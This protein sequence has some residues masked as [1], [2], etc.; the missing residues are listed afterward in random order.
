MAKPIS[1]AQYHAIIARF[2][3]GS[4]LAD[5][6]ESTYR[7]LTQNFFDS[8]QPKNFLQAVLA[9][10]IAYQTAQAYRYRK[11]KNELI[12]RGRRKEA[13]TRLKEERDWARWRADR[14]NAMDEAMARHDPTYVPRP[15]R[16]DPCLT[17][18]S[19]PLGPVADGVVENLD[20]LDRI[21]RLHA[22]ALRHREH[23]LATLAAYQ[24]FQQR[25]AGNE[26]VD[27][28]DA[29]F[30]R[31]T[32]I[33]DQAPGAGPA[34]AVET[35]AIP[36]PMTSAAAIEATSVQNSVLIAPENPS[37]A[38]TPDS[39]EQTGVTEE[40]APSLSDHERN[41]PHVA[42]YSKAHRRTP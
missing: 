17:E 32:A 8:V 11:M 9:E 21:D 27:I 4:T 14:A 26:P 30:H 7:D 16:L 24:A 39:T 1:P 18:D 40:P 22:C 36:A 38:H 42:A 31:T 34:S 20:N 10:E 28:I 23:T 33:A 19:L 35:R 13:E 2:A 41:Y 25:A 6:D 37:F 15:I 5:E 29:E 12:D 3:P